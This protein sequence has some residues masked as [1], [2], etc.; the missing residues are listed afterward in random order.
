[1][2]KKLSPSMRRILKA[3]LF[4][5]PEGVCPDF[6]SGKI[7]R[8]LEALKRRGLATMQLCAPSR[9]EPASPFWQITPEGKEAVKKLTTQRM[10]EQQ[11]GEFQ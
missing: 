4:A 2:T 11:R 10:L 8:T 5:E 1:M 3:L 6:T 7:T 9:T